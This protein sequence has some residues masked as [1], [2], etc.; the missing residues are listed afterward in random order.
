MPNVTQPLVSKPSC[1]TIIGQEPPHHVTK[2]YSLLYVKCWSW[3]MKM[4][5]D[6]K[7]WT[8]NWHLAHTNFTY[9]R[10]KLC[11]FSGTILFVI[12][13]F[14]SVMLMYDVYT[15]YTVQIRTFLSRINFIKLLWICFR[16]EIPCLQNW[17]SQSLTVE[18]PKP[19]GRQQ[20]RCAHNKSWH[21][22]LYKNTKNTHH[23]S[24]FGSGR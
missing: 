7:F 8:S 20:A 18:L 9:M 3:L 16:D 22:R 24:V 19:L 10:K 14:Y 23:M 17:L 12:Q 13:I 6:T 5:G 21:W 2:S 15:V 4:V 1:H 11:L